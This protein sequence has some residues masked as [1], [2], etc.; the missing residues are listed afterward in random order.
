MRA[1]N[2]TAA[3]GFCPG[4]PCAPGDARCAEP[5]GA[6]GANF[7]ASLALVPPRRGGPTTVR[8][9]R[10]RRRPTACPAGNGSEPQPRFEVEDAI[11][12]GDVGGVREA[13][14]A[15]GKI[16]G[17]AQ[18]GQDFD[19][20]AHWWP[21]CQENDLDEAVPTPFTLL[22]EEI[23]IWKDQQGT[24]RVMRDLCPHRLVPLSEGRINED[25]LLECGYH[26][27]T[28]SPDGACTA[29]PQAADAVA[30]VGC[31]CRRSHV[32]VFQSTVAQGLLWV[33]LAPA[34]PGVPCDTSDVPVLPELDEEGWVM[35]TLVRDLPYDYSTLMENVM[36]V[37]HVPWTHHG[38]VGDRKDACVVDLRVVEKGRWGF[39]GSW[40]SGPMQGAY[41]PQSTAFYAPG[42][43]VQALDCRARGFAAKTVVYATPMA[44]G[45]SRVVVRFPFW[46][47][48][49]P[50]R[51]IFRAVPDAWLHPGA[52][53]VLEDDQVFLHIGERRL[54]SSSVTEPSI[55]RLYYMPSTADAYTL[56][57][58][59]WLSTVGNGGPFQR[60][61]ASYI[62]RLG[63]ELSR[64]DLMDRFHSHT[65]H[66]K[67]CRGAHQRLVRG[68]AVAH[69]AATA[70]AA[71]AG[72]IVALEK[73]PF[74]D[75]APNGDATAM[76]IGGAV[77]LAAAA[78]E[79]ASW[80]FKSLQTQYVSGAYPPPRNKQGLRLGALAEGVPG[81]SSMPD[82]LGIFFAWSVALGLFEKQQG[83]QREGE[84]RRPGDGAAP[85]A[86][87]V[88]LVCLLAL[89][90]FAGTP[91]AGS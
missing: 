80:A 49:A 26:G 78:L 19:W 23:V 50:L 60:P 14:F 72:A 69:G 75:G 57:Y 58:R 54:F 43:T 79:A 13:V 4:R 28:F 1:A 59:E 39:K 25:G 55:A 12:D 89:L 81:M 47:D 21:V 29:I 35:T 3:K 11:D 36:D 41:G 83:V 37:S 32:Q 44:P 9:A 91:R 48:F 38:T 18:D 71:A 22:S 20:K 24:W 61:D 77:V 65:K 68:Q 53:G 16:E 34:V 5:A 33:K 74:A 82:V 56:A 40:D 67:S 7:K 2:I 6:E 52:N 45:R 85:A 66:C 30:S 63:P 15:C 42:L 31:A 8:P 90:A 86:S 64:K 51:W 88:L 76:Q 62:D 84:A 87:T 46:F 27:W 17:Q 73:V 70:L 10:P